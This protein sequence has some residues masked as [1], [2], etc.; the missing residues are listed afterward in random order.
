[1]YHWDISVAY[2]N[3]GSHAPTYVRFPNNFPDDICSGYT[4]GTLARLTK[5]LHGSK[6]TM[7]RVDT[8]GNDFMH[9]TVKH[10]AAKVRFLQEC[11]QHKIVRRTYAATRENGAD[12]MT[13]QSNGPQFKAA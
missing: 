7:L 12:M 2:S 4:G 11:V 1:M 8:T 10:V 6:S 13:K 5:N 3:A 9:E